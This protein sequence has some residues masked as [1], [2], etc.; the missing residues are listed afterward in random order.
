[1]PENDSKHTKINW[2]KMPAF[3]LKT[4]ANS[5]HGKRGEDS[6]CSEAEMPVDRISQLQ[7]C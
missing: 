7:H 4:S 1:M 6:R 5:S 3:F 2:D